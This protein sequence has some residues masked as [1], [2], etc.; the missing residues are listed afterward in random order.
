MEEKFYAVIGFDDIYGGLHGMVEREVIYGTEDYAWEVAK[1]L[2]ESVI[3]S[4]G[5]IE[6]DLEA[7]TQNECDFYGIDD[8]F[9]DEANVIRESLWAEDVRTNICELDASKLPTEDL[10][11]LTDMFNNNPSDFIDKYAR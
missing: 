8:Y 7:A 11:E 4:Y 9:S 3:S 1:G 5:Q 2:A 6:D 10:H